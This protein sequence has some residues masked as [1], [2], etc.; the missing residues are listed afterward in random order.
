MPDFE[1]RNSNGKGMFAFTVVYCAYGWFSHPLHSFQANTLIT[2]TS[3]T[4]DQTRRMSRQIGIDKHTRSSFLS[5]TNPL[6]IR[7]LPFLPFRTDASL[8]SCIPMHSKTVHKHLT[9]RSHSAES[10]CL[11]NSAMLMSRQIGATKNRSR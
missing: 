3:R 5:I 11:R 2:C 10:I 4:I 1:I 6:K 9:T 7:S 8:Y